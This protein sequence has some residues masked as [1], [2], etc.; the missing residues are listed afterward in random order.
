MKTLVLDHC[1]S[2]YAEPFYKY[3]EVMQA[4]LPSEAEIASSD[5][6]VFI[7]GDDVNPY[8][9]DTKPAH[10]S[11]YDL[12]NDGASYCI[13]KVAKTHG[14]PCVGI[15]KGGQLLA[16]FN[17]DKMCQH[18]D[19][20]VSRHLALV[21]V[22]DLASRAIPKG[23]E[24]AVTSSHHQIFSGDNGRVLVRSANGAPCT[25][26]AVYGTDLAIQ[27]HPEWVSEDSL[28]RKLFEGLLELHM[29]GGELLCDH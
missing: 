6:V 22:D 20:H 7:G 14:I 28:E 18:V 21:V 29:T 24:L 23:T 13:W 10:E 8:L 2:Q 9:Y 15:C 16:V 27:F 1:P 19:N 11:Y 5:L 12:Y 25:E 4:M 3:G 26:A 17:G